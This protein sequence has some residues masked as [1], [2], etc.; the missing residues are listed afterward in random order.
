VLGSLHAYLALR[1]G[2]D[3]VLL[4]GKRPPAAS[5]KK[6]T[7]LFDRFDQE[8]SEDLTGYEL[9]HTPD[10]HNGIDRHPPT[11]CYADLLAWTRRLQEFDLADVIAVTC[12]QGVPEHHRVTRVPTARL[13]LRQGC[14]KLGPR[15]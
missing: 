8:K 9:L 13:G 15:R 4:N 2:F 1:A 3:V 12:S 5:L 10:R 7:G 6:S 14:E 11:C